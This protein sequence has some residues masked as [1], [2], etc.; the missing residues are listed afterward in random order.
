MRALFDKFYEAILIV[1]RTSNSSVHLRFQI[2]NAI[3]D[4]FQKIEN[5]FQESRYHYRNFVLAAY[6]TANKKLDK[7]YNRI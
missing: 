5:I 2:F 4:H 3:F 1:S 6:E 7:Y